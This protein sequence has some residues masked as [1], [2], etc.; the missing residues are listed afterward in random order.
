MRTVRKRT[1]HASPAHKPA[2]NDQVLR[3]E[4][5]LT[6]NPSEAEI[7]A[8]AGNDPRAGIGLK[9]SMTMEVFIGTRHSVITYWIELGGETARHDAVIAD[10][11][12]VIRA[13]GVFKTD[14]SIHPLAEMEKKPAR[15]LV[16]V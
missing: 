7:R 4:L 11:A 14:G 5:N 12:E 15:H 8:I 2:E 3:L 13:I 10:R 1:V 6:T 16:A 9:K